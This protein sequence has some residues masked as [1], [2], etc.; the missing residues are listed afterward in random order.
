MAK[1]GIRLKD[2]RIF[3]YY[4]V[5]F[6]ESTMCTKRVDIEWRD[7]ESILKFMYFFGGITIVTYAFILIKMIS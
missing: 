3:L 2:E 7:C 6:P 4:I 5:Y 1:C